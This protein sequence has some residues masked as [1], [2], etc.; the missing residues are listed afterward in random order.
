MIFNTELSAKEL[1]LLNCVAGEDS[2]ESLELQWDQI[3]S[4]NSK[5]NQPWI[6]IGRSDA[7]A[8]ILW[9]PNE[10]SWLIGK[11]LD[12]GKDWRQKEKGG[13]RMI[14]LDNIT[15]SMDMNLSK[16]WEIVEDRGAWHPA[17]HGVVKSR[18]WLS[19]WTASSSSLGLGR[20]HPRGHLNDQRTQSG[21]C[22]S[23]EM[24][25][26]DKWMVLK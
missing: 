10:K 5:G 17:A 15:Y 1:I 22:F 21:L 25:E 2:W 26:G 8:P 7:E 18:I 24:E 13:Q 23:L 9:P 16:L 11:D 20:T 6:F 14:C 4:V 19:D 3:R 12:I